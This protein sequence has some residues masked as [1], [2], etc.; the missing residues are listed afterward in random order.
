[1][2]FPNK[3]LFY[4]GSV[5]ARCKTH[6]AKIILTMLLISTLV[7]L[8]T[9][10]MWTPAE[11]VYTTDGFGIFVN[12]KLIVPTITQEDAEEILNG[13]NDCY[14]RE[15]STVVDMSYAEDVQI[16][17]GKITIQDVR[18]VEE[19]ISFIVDRKKPLITVLSQ[20]MYSVSEN[21]QEE[22]TYSS[23]A[24]YTYDIFSKIKAENFSG[25][26]EY[27]VLLTLENNIILHREVRNERLV[28]TAQRQEG[29]K[30]LQ[31]TESEEMSM[32]V[33][34]TAPVELNITSPYGVSRMETGYHLG[35]DF[36][37]PVG[38]PILAAAE[39]V[40]SY[41]GTLGSYGKL[42][43]INHG[44]NVQT[45]YSHCRS[46]DVQEG[47]TVEAGDYIGSVG[48]TGRTTGPHLHFELRLNGGTLDPMDYL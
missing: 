8:I 44:G 7:L 45:Y 38:T 28:V 15:N 21:V 48:S 37:N 19:S 14:T 46:I 4:V 39:G 18:S 43:I 34:L 13:V 35:V 6:K 9:S 11:A 30:G 26:R 22:T 5:K 47:D 42:I 23:S 24:E 25:T 2:R 27:E 33:R 20:Q 12:G 41:V 1:M 16:K 3:K 17:E 29:Y 10:L 36:Y 31:F 40:V 32:V